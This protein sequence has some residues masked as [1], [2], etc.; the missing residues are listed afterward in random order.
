MLRLLLPALALILAA[1]TPAEPPAP[2]VPVKP[3]H[4]VKRE[5]FFGVEAAADP[6]VDW[7]STGLGIK[8]L[9]PGEGT[10]PT[11]SDRVRVHYTGSLA[12]GTVFDD[13]RARGQPAEFGLD[14]LVRGMADGLGFMKPGG[15]AILYIPPS[16]GYGSMQAGNIPP[17]SGLIFDIELIAILP[18]K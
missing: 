10:A 18:P 1:C 12:N 14:R 4:V 16:L 9:V 11:F 5:K 3:D 7:R 8:I 17:V 2:P 13:T 15:R 6:A